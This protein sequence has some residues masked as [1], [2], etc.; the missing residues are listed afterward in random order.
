MKHRTT[1]VLLAF[2]T[3]AAVS[4]S[5]NAQPTLQKVLLAEGTE[6]PLSMAQD[7]SSRAARSGEPIIVPSLR[8]G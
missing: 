3:M 2:M 6:V 5:Q 4:L 7:I 8:S 1:T